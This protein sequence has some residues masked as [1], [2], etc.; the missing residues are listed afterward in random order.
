MRLLSRISFWVFAVLLLA[1]LVLAGKDYYRILGVD[2]SA[3]KREIKKAYKDLSKKYHPDKNPGDKAA[4]EKFIELATAYQVLSDDDQRRTY[5][6][7][8]EEGLKNA[9]QERKGPEINM[10]LQVTLEELFLGDSIEAS[11]VEINK[12]IIC[13]VCRGSGAKRAE[14]VTTCHVCGGNGVKVV[15]QM[16]GPGIY[17]QM[18]TTCDA[19]GGRGKVIK[20]KCSACAGHKVKRGSHQF[21]V[22]VE[23]GMSDGQ[24]IVFEQEGDESP[25]I[26][27]G[28]VVFIVRTVP[29][30][31]FTRKGSNLYMKEVLTL[32]EALLG[33]QKV[34][35][36]LDG[37]DLTISRDGVTQPGFVQTIKGQ[38]M[39]THEFPSERGDLYVEYSV[40]FPSTLSST[41]AELAEKL[42]AS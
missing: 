25:D 22:T 27:P 2:R 8:G 19:C 7:Y 41:Q 11:P 17:Q 31:V 37:K 30:P 40:V 15:R 42:F 38:G 5:D 20:S 23:R 26:T 34:V 12:Q 4:E 28:D 32:K 33:F 14:D 24:R 1:D 13:P 29:H 16:L 9:H 21:T 6:Q 10:D 39:P 36:H 3:S 18:Q 35:K